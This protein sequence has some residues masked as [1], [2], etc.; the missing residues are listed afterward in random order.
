MFELFYVG[1]TDITS[2]EPDD[3]MMVWTH[4]LLNPNVYT[5]RRLLMTIT[6]ICAIPNTA[7]EYN[8][9]SLNLPVLELG[10]TLIIKYACTYPKVP[11]VQGE[12]LRRHFPV[13]LRAWAKLLI[14]MHG[15][16]LVTP[17]LVCCGNVLY[18]NASVTH[19]LLQRWVLKKQCDSR[20]C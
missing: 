17:H 15:P 4:R 1:N 13:K 3:T 12:W 5:R 18:N 11:V 20:A 8:L 6:T 2:A 14:V 10:T 19:M 16:C 7:L 9:A